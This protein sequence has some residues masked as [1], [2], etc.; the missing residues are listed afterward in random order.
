[1]QGKRAQGRKNKKLED[2]RQSANST[3]ETILCAVEDLSDTQETL[4]AEK[5]VRNAKWC[6]DSG[7]TSHLCGQLRKF[8]EIDDLRRGKLNLA[9]HTSTEIKTIETISITAGDKRNVSL[10]NVLHVPDLPENLLSVANIMD[11]NLKVI[12]RKDRAVVVDRSGN[13]KLCANRIRNLY[14]LSERERA[15]CHKIWDDVSNASKDLKVWHRRLEH[16]NVALDIVNGERN[17]ILRGL[18]IEKCEGKLEC[19]IC[20]RGKMTD[21]PFP[22]TSENRSKE[23]LKIIHSNLC[24]PMRVESKGG[25]K[26]FVTFIDDYSKWCEVRFLRNKSD[27]FNAFKEIKALVENRTERRIK[28][29]QSDNGRE[30]LSNEFENFVKT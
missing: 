15:E 3:E 11:K 6:L 27:A 23:L 9:N 25:A 20:I 10:S 30:Y 17:K 26:Y 28:M 12:F 19:E 21:T 16:L 8:A 18:N 7:V 4:R 13:V 14:F 2:Y 29:L 5:G 22:A 1:M 24:G